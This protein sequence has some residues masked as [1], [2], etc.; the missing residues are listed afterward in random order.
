MVKLDSQVSRPAQSIAFENRADL[1][2]GAWFGLNHTF[3]SSASISRMKS[4]KL[5]SNI[6]YSLLKPHSHSSV[7]L[8]HYSNFIIGCIIIL[9][10]FSL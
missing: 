7:V 9:L 10:L 6:K 1:Q 8:V 2:I 4:K 3:K 5:V